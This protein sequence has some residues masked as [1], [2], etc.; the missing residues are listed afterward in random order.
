M[1]V[2]EFTKLFSEGSKLSGS[3]T[4]TADGLPV[5]SLYATRLTYIGKCLRDREMNGRDDS[6]FYMLVWDDELNAPKEICYATTRGWSYPCYG[7]FV[8][9]T[10]EVKAKYEAYIK[11]RARNSK[12]AQ[13]RSVRSRAQEIATQLEISRAAALKLMYACADQRWKLEAVLKLFTS[14]LRSPMRIGF[15]EQ[16]HTWLTDPAPKYASPLSARQW[17]LLHPMRYAQTPRGGYNAAT[18]SSMSRADTA[19]LI[20]GDMLKKNG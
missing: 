12:A 2:I 11:L 6:D 1:A 15:K 9:A 14:N 16:T 3:Q 4:T 18:I 20:I 8:D 10:P 7:S 5:T 13:I 19:A 17:P